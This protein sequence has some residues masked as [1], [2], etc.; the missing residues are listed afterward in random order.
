MHLERQ[1]LYQAEAVCNY[2]SDFDYLFFLVVHLVAEVY[3]H[4]NVQ[5]QDCIEKLH[6]LHVWSQVEPNLIEAFS[7]NK[8]QVDRN[9]D[10]HEAERDE[11]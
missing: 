3:H 8:R 2:V 9:S 6:S 5:A 4:D 11:S 1:S 10:S 7:Q